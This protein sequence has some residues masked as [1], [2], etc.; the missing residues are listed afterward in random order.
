MRGRHDGE[1]G[2]VRARAHGGRAD[3]GPA[4][5]G[6]QAVDEGQED[7]VPV[8]AAALAVLCLLHHDQPGERKESVQFSV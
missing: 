6:A 1:R 4:E 3:P 5:D 2:H 8:A 7:D